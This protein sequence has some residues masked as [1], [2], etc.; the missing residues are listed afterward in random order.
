MFFTKKIKRLWVCTLS[1]TTMITL[2]FIM[3]TFL[4]LMKAS[5]FDFI[6]SSFYTIMLTSITITLIYIYHKKKPFNKMISNALLLNAIMLLVYSFL[7]PRFP[8]HLQTYHFNIMSNGDSYLMDGWY[9]LAGLLLLLFSRI[10]HYGFQLQEEV[11][12]IV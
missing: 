11:D 5:T 4:A 6:R 9:F 10:F 8:Q 12:D 2:V 3:H 7:L 1:L